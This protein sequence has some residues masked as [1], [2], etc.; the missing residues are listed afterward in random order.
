L[1]AAAAV[2]PVVLLA[3]FV[4]FWLNLEEN[5]PSSDEG[6]KREGVK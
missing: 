2:S 4:N 1:F 6:S 5:K 3:P